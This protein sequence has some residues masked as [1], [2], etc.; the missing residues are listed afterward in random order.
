M[1]PEDKK[2]LIFLHLLNAVVDRN[3]HIS[4]IMSPDKKIS[5]TKLDFS[6]NKFLIRCSDKDLL[7]CKTGN[8]E[9]N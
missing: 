4:R 8:I 6:F 3:L 5:K 9:W 1:Q 2:P 7:I